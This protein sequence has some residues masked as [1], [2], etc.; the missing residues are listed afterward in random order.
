M[1]QARLEEEVDSENDSSSTCSLGEVEKAQ[2]SISIEFPGPTTC[3]GMEPTVEGQS[4]SIQG[5]RLVR[6]SALAPDKLSVHATNGV[7]VSPSKCYAAQGVKIQM[8]NPFP[9]RGDQGATCSNLR[10][11]M[12]RRR[13]LRRP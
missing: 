3:E 10:S 9:I 4:K 1:H 8:T 6:D 5:S 2:K 12:P 11:K 13:L 7:P